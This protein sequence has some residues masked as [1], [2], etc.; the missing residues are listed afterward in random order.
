MAKNRGHNEGS[1]FKRG[2]NTWRAQ[3]TIQG[4]RLSFNG[5]SKKECQEW[6]KE[7]LAQVDN[8]LIYKSAKL[9]LEEFMTDWLISVESSLR[10]NTYK[11]Y[12]QI[13]NQHILP[14]LG[15]IKLKDLNPADIQQRYNNMVKQGKGLRTVQITHAVIHRALGQAVKF[16]LISRNPDDATTPPKPK[17]KE[18]KFYDQDQVQKLLLSA[19][20]SGD[21]NYS[22]Y[23]LALSTGMRQAEILGLRWTDLDIEQRSLQVHRQ[24][25]RKKGG[26]FEFTSP[27]TKAGIR[28]LTLG[29]STL[30][31]LH[32]HKQVQ[33]LQIQN[34]GDAWQDHDLI[35][36]TLIGTPLDKYNLLKS[37]KKL[38]RKIGLPQI[39]FH[40]LRHTAASLMLN[41][42]IPVIVV[43]KRLGHSKPSV[44]LDI[45]GHLIPSKQQEAA[46]IM[47][48]LLSPIE[49]Q[50][51]N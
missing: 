6:V 5:K 28:K 23:Q 17:P 18:M 46:L 49:V 50:F 24:L 16:G 30:E 8:G 19:K 47:D 40:D 44:T 45:Y 41:H 3:I 15:K 13:T 39:R 9:T 11:Q 25:T 21:P 26:G 29:Q 51:S 32:D 34:A 31:I 38:V 22:L 37:F 35:F 33:F 48:E 1:I 2:N 27:K 42:G 4:K 20:S 43:S 36:T 14:Y 7:T 10:P 12:R